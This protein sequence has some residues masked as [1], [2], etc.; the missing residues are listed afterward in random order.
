[1]LVLDTVHIDE[2]LVCEKPEMLV[3]INSK[4]KRIDFFI[5]DDIKDCDTLESVRNDQLFIIDNLSLVLDD[6]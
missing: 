4:V 3:M 6:T 1:M 5:V 2:T